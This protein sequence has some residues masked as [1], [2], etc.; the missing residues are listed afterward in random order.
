MIC[1]MPSRTLLKNPGFTLVAVATLALGIGAN[2][3]IFSVVNGVLLRPLP[4][5]EPDR[6]VRVS[7]STPDEQR[8][9]HSAG[10]FMDLR[11]EQQSLQA[12]AG[13]RSLLFT[14][15]ARTADAS[16]LAGAFVTAEFFDVLGVP[17]AFGRRF[18]AVQDTAAGE[19]RVVLSLHAFTQLYGDQ[20]DAVGQALR[21]N[22][23]AHT[24]VGVLP[25]GSGWPAGADVW[26]L[27]DKEV[28][29]SPLDLPGPRQP[30]ATC[31]IS[32]RSHA[33]S[34]ASRSCRH[35]R[36]SAASRRSSKAA[37]RRP[38]RPATS[39][40]SICERTSSA[41]CA[42]GCSSFKRPSA[43]VLVIACANV[44]SL[45]IARASG[46]RRELAIRAA[47]GAGRARLVRQLLTESALLGIAG[48]LVGLLVGSWMIG[49]LIA[50]P[51]RQRP[52]HRSHLARS[53]GGWSDD[54]HG[55]G[56]RPAL[57]RHACPA[58]VARSGTGRAQ[59]RRRSRG[60]ERRSNVRALG[61]G[62]RRGRPHACAPGWVRASFS[63]AC[64]D[65]SVST[66]A[67]GRTT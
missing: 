20:S 11:R 67:C 31:G 66:R 2:T 4:F 45:L 19:R 42:S 47:L 16:Q 21:V 26:V 37:A 57:R 29:P 28:P 59:T 63:T 50:R 6:I 39:G 3:A 65:S 52:A 7:T 12:L 49:L 1:D 15:A 40:S 41:T 14:V 25:A 5:P 51:A 32:K 27:S 38:Q 30:T 64:S 34:L 60:H 10:D 13:Y 36:T 18:S 55:A 33:S 53:R 23:Q 43:L 62:S 48:G 24:L 9:N 56:D 61:T 58:G 35:N 54:P 44:A 46:R 17:A 8:S 22:G